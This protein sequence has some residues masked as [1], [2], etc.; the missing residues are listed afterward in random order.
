[1]SVLFGRKTAGTKFGKI[2][3]ARGLVIALYLVS[4]LFSF[5]ATHLSQTNNFNVISCTM[6]IY[7]CIILYASSK[8]IIYFFL[9]EKVYV[10][11]AVGMTR[12]EFKLYKVNLCLMLPFFGIIALMVN[13]RVAEVNEQGECHIGL[14]RPATLP[15]ILYDMF[16]SS[17]LT[18]LFIHPLRSSRSMLQGPSKSRLRDVARRTLIGAVVALFLSSANVFTL[19]YFEGNE[20]GLICL[21]S[22]TADV[23]LNAIAIHWVT[24]RAS[25]K[26][27]VEV[28][29]GLPVLPIKS[30]KNQNN[31]N[32]TTKGVDGTGRGV[33]HG[34]WG[35]L[36]EISVSNYSHGHPI[37]ERHKG[38][39]DSH[40]YITV[41]AY[42]DEHHH[43]SSQPMNDNTHESSYP[44]TALSAPA[45]S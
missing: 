42:L 7:I 39:F 17:W 35:E 20:R 27:S 30:S 44:P 12:K 22:C 41:E 26:S 24:S 3:Y 37:P 28:G 2:N 29:V 14:L 43:S 11:T 34:V 40:S 21:S 33:W 4:W 15:L 31:N 1:M 8:I 25:C 10:V 32:G 18:L 9:M 36:D 16:L 13:Y 6:S 23:T 5:I 38:S 45:E 19:V